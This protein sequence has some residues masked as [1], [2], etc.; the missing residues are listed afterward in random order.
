MAGKDLI[1]DPSQYDLNR[2]IADIHEIRRYNPQRFEMEQLT[3]VVHED[4]ERKIGVGYKDQTPNEFWVKGH[5]PQ[6]ALLPGI[7]MC[8]SAAQLCS[9]L[10]RKHDLLGSEIMGFGGLDQIKFRDPVLVGDRLV[11]VVALEKLRKGAMVVCRFQG[12]VRES[13]VVEGRIKGVPLPIE[14]FTTAAGQPAGK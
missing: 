13:L 1:L 5:M 2:V 10:C 9:Y 12:F 11:L 7:L 4:L 8:E 6:F 3:A 14:R